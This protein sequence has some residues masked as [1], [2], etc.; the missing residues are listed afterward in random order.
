M[1]SKPPPVDAFGKVRAFFFSSQHQQSQ[2]HINYLW[3]N[4]VNVS[5]EESAAL[6]QLKR[7][8]GQSWHLMCHWWDTVWP[9]DRCSAP[10]SL[11]F[12][13]SLCWLLSNCPDEGNAAAR[14]WNVVKQ[15]APEHTD[16]DVE[17][18]T[19]QHPPWSPP[20]HFPQPQPHPVHADTPTAA[21]AL[22]SGAPFYQHK[23][24][25]ME[26]FIS[27]FTYAACK[28]VYQ[29]QRSPNY[30]PL[31][32]IERGDAALLTLLLYISLNMS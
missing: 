2:R 30:K 12:Q 13:L 5:Q 6:L 14:C 4:Q 27:C 31:Y 21:Q 11:T 28:G 23:D 29:M 3:H 26:I 24:K 15:C 25:A 10:S 7:D 17:D 22:C 9:F 20:L 18:K 1:N 16:G 32:T 19:L 8:R